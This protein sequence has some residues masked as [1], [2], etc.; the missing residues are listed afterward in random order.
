[1]LLNNYKVSNASG[2]Y[3]DVILHQDHQ[4]AQSEQ[5]R[6]LVKFYGGACLQ[7]LAPAS[8]LTDGHLTML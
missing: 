3:P 5:L 7:Q 4:G 2:C 1:M 6:T 8:S